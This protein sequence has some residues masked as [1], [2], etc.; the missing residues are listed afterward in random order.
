MKLIKLS[1]REA[2]VLRAIE[3]LGSTGAEIFDRT[4]IAVADL[5]DVLNALYEIGYVEAYPPGS[6]VP[7]MEPVKESAVLTTRFEINPSYQLELK[8][9][10]TRR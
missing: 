1:G 7:L 2:A 4:Q 9:A 3:N 5:A 6:Q 10:L 8:K